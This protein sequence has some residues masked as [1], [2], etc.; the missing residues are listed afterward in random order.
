MQLLG[1]TTFETTT[2]YIARFKIANLNWS[3]IKRP[4][5]SINYYHHCH[6]PEVSISKDFYHLILLNTCSCISFN[7]PSFLFLSLT[8][9]LPFNYFIR[10]LCYHECECVWEG[11]GDLLTF[12]MPSFIC[13]YFTE[14]FR[15]VLC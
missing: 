8:R 5:K 9:S 15:V 10:S 2:I 12:T 11:R 7:C 4:K 1:S 3:R 6:N 14:L 13:F